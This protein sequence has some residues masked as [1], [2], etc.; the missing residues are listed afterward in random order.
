MAFSSLVSANGLAGSR[1]AAAG[2]QAAQAKSPTAAP[3]YYYSFEDS[4][5]S[6]KPATDSRE[7]TA[8]VR[9][10]GDEGC[11]DAGNHYANL[12]SSRI[13]D[14]NPGP[15]QIPQ[16]LGTWM[17]VAL[18]AVGDPIGVNVQFA[19]SSRNKTCTNCFVAAYAGT[20][21]PTY[22]S[23]LKQAGALPEQGWKNYSAEFKLPVG[24]KDGLYVAIGWQGIDASVGID[25]I[26]ITVTKS[27]ADW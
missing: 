8:L 6:W 7:A 3:V 19:A 27:K 16:P 25:C 1:A 18:P 11:T 22:S 13:N 23:D 9:A 14:S 2:L 5:G 12:T 21:R 10:E 20:S 4:L 24:A 26:S 15:D 17:L